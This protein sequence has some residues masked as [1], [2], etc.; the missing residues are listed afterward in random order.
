MG[1]GFRRGVAFL[2]RLFFPQAEK[3]KSCEN[4]AGDRKLRVEGLETRAQ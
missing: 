4:R 3:L 1:Q 2:F